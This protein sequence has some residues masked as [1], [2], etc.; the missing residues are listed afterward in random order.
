MTQLKINTCSGTPG[1]DNFRYKLPK[2]VTKA[3]LTKATD[4]L[5][6]SYELFGK[7]NGLSC[8]EFLANVLNDILPGLHFDICTHFARLTDVESLETNEHD[9]SRH[10]F[11]SDDGISQCPLCRRAPA[12]DNEG[13]GLCEQCLAIP[14]T[15]KTILHRLNRLECDQRRESDNDTNPPNHTDPIVNHTGT[16]YTEQRD[17]GLHATESTGPALSPSLA[18]AN[19]NNSVN[20]NAP[21]SAQL[22]DYRNKHKQLFTEAHTSSSLESVDPPTPIHDNSTLTESLNVPVDVDSSPQNITQACKLM[23]QMDWLIIVQIS[24]PPRHVKLMLQTSGINKSPRT[25]TVVEN[26]PWPTHS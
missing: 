6:P 23:H 8:A 11:I 3:S 26:T 17:Y 9:D 20:D 4:Y 2:Y 19:T 7:D 12:T 13:I 10:I 5:K 16:E 1:E 24:V 15:I 25:I 21:L 18:E 22:S 14:D